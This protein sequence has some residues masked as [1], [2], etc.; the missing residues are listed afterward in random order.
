M[1][2]RLPGISLSEAEIANALKSLFSDGGGTTTKTFEVKTKGFKEVAK[3]TKE[4]TEGLR[5]FGE[6]LNTLSKSKGGQGAIS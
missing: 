4:A 6:A 3:E 2:D 5:G 1:A